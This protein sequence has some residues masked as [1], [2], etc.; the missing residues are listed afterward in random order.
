M[1]AK[2]WRDIGATHLTLTT[3]GFVPLMKG[4]AAR[5]KRDSKDEADP[6]DDLGARAHRAR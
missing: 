1:K 4:S 6:G 2:A 5:E 3:L